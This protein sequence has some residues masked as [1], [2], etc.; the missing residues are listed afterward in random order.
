MEKEKNLKEEIFNKIEDSE[1]SPDHKARLKELFEERERTTMFCPLCKRL[2]ITKD[3]FVY[4]DLV[5][6]SYSPKYE[7]DNK[8]C[9]LQKGNCFWNENGDYFSGDLGFTRSKELFPDNK[10]AALNSFA[11]K[12]EVEIYKHGLKRETRL[13]PAFCLWIV[14]PL[15]EHT[16]KSNY[17]GDVLKRGWKLKFLKKNKTLGKG[18]NIYC[19]PN[20]FRMFNFLLSEFK[21]DK[22]AFFNNPTESNK[23]DVLKHFEKNEWD[24]RWWRVLFTF[25]INTF[26]GKVKKLIINTE[27]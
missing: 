5:G 7:C 12:S 26:Y 15:I 20:G 1:M 21:R 9:E 17:F 27:L 19:G 6:N 18:Y 13:H 23:K 14:Q 10:Y 4:N 22:K 16:Y 3:W 24:N 8:E 11:K 25:F 2:L